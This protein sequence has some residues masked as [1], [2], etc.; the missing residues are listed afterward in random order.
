MKIGNADLSEFT[1]TPPLVQD[2][3]I[4]IPDSIMEYNL[5]IS[6]IDDGINEG[7]NGTE[8]WF[9]RYQMDPCDVPT[10]RIHP[11]GARVQ[12]AIPV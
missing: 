9:I 8:N 6:A 1:I 4:M 11:D 10:L 7:T 2:S 5:T 3:L 12:Q